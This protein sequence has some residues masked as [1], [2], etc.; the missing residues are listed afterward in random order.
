MVSPLRSIDCADID[1][2]LVDVVSE[3]EYIPVGE[4]VKI[5]ARKGTCLV[6]RTV[7]KSVTQEL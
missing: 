6:V 4:V 7:G 5:V 3:Q 1:G 2:R